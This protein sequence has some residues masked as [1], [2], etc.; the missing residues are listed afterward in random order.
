MIHLQL[1][2]GVLLLAVVLVIYLLWA[3]RLGVLTEGG[4]NEEEEEH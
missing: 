3:K 4:R 2:A 1:A